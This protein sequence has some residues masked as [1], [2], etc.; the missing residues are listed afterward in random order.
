[1]NMRLI[2]V[3]IVFSS[4]MISCTD[5]R[6]V[7]K[8]NDKQAKYDMAINL[9]KAGK[10]VKAYPIFEQLNIEYRGTDK[11]EKIAYYQTMCDFK[12][13]DYILAEHRFSQFSRNYP[14]SEYA[15]DCYFLS[16]FCNYQMSPVYSLDQGETLKAMR[17]F[18]QFAIDYPQSHKID[19]VNF[20]IDELRKKIEYKEYKGAMLYFKMEQYRAASTALSEF[21]QR[22][23]N[24]DFR[25]EV[26]FS[27]LVSS[28]QLAMNSVES[29][30]N[31]RI[32]SAIKA[33]TTFASRFPESKKLKNADEMHSELIQEL[34]ISNN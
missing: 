33:Y 10:Y 1:M 12:M 20:F 22:Y 29:K 2:L 5:Y 23:P 11:G 17:Q 19:S 4:A 9:Y 6:K 15:E 26:Q 18:Q 31:E 13:K 14:N 27:I 21:V 7:V 3:F 32:E 25:E 16:A 24:S 8:G 28:Y 30:K 34:E